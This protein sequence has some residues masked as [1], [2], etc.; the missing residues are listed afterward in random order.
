MCPLDNEFL[1][2][3]PHFLLLHHQQNVFE[4]GSKRF[5][6]LYSYDIFEEFEV[7]CFLF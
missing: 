6:L 1:D 5:D 7:H 3:L 2:M 4:E